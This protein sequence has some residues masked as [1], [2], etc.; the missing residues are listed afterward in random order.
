MNWCLPIFQVVVLFARISS[1]IK[2]EGS[3]G[4]DGREMR[5]RLA[6]FLALLKR[7]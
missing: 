4:L 2:D 7:V 5:M 1:R 3:E 6:K